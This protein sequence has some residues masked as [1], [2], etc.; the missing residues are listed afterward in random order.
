[1][2]PAVILFLLIA[3]LDWIAVRRG[4]KRVE[5]FAK[6]AAMLVLAGLLVFAGGFRNLP[7]TCFTVGILFS[8]AGDIFLMVN[9]T[10]FGL[11]WFILG[12]G[13]FLLA[14]AAYIVGLNVP[15]PDVS[16]LWSTG[17]ALLLALTASRLLRRIITGVRQKGL[18]RLALPVA[19]YGVVITLML[20]SALLTIYRTDWNLGAAGLVSLGAVLFFASDTILAWNKFINPTWNGRLVNMITYHLG[21]LALTVGVLLQ[22]P[23]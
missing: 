18:K 14:H 16:P 12:L 5:Y 22:F 17:L 20:L 15:L 19:V 11:R 1:M 21:Q 13:A 10:R 2:I 6:P 3:V 9:L 23:G 7:L 8:L 4:W